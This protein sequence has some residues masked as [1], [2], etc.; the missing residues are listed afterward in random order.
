MNVREHT[1]TQN[2]QNKKRK[3]QSLKGV[4]V[5]AGRLVVHLFLRIFAREIPGGNKALRFRSWRWGSFALF[6]RV[7]GK[8]IEGRTR[9]FAGVFAG[10]FAGF[11]A[12]FVAG[13]AAGFVAGFFAGLLD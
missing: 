11:V 6:E 8:D 5:G 9:L 7:G 10:V 1:S 4:G 13:F 3:P 12:G 2:K